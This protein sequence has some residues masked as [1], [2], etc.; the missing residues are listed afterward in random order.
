MVG[1]SVAIPKAKRLW[2]RL[3]VVAALL[4]LATGMCV[5]W[6]RSEPAADVR[7]YVSIGDSYAAG[8]RP[9]G[10]D[11]PGTSHDSFVYLVGDKLAQ[12]QS[13]WQVVNFGCT[14]ETAH[15][16][17]FDNGCEPS[18][19]APGGAQ[20]PNM[21][22][23]MAAV[24]FIEKHRSQIGLVTL[25]AGGNDIMQCIN[26][27][28]AAAVQS[29]AETAITNVKQ[30]LDP[31]VE[32]IRSTVGP[33][34]P[35]VG[36]SY[37]NVFNADASSD[38]PVVAQRAANARNLFQNYLNPTLLDIYTRHG[39]EF[40]NSTDLADGN[41]SDSVKSWLP[42][43]GTVPSSVAKVCTL[44][45]YCAYSDPHPNPAGHAMIAGEIERLMGL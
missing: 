33:T 29:C 18:A 45:Y 10:P 3:G 12:T 39:A 23:A 6:A 5:A 31:L 38:D 22:Q 35:I 43:R 11:G 26:Q 9:T 37:I 20:Y 4:I 32:H 16:M 14:G 30:T 2:G 13:G 24:D 19:E 34:V 44:T 28:D 15:S 7:Y 17:A 25:A 1:D 21:P 36:V 27:T 8:Y 41:L 42:D 40:V